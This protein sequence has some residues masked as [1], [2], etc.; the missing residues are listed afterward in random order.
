MYSL[1]IYSCIPPSPAEYDIN[2]VCPDLSLNS[3]IELKDTNNVDGSNF[4]LKIGKSFMHYKKDNLDIKFNP[5]SKEIFNNGQ[6]FKEVNE[7]YY[8]N[9]D[10]FIYELNNFKNK[11]WINF[12]LDDVIDCVE[13][14]KY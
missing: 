7:E 10:K 3:R 13:K 6:R 12:N 14:S 11:S 2:Q 9:L 4:Y 5:V 1:L 8:T